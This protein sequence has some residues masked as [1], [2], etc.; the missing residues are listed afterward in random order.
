MA[1]NQ[2][3]KKVW[4]FPLLLAFLVM[5]LAGQV[6]VMASGNLPLIEAGSARV[7]GETVDIPVTLRNISGIESGSFKVTAAQGDKL[8]LEDISL[9][10]REFNCTHKEVPGDMGDMIEIQFLS[11]NG[12]MDIDHRGVEVVYLTY[13]LGENVEAGETLDIKLTDVNLK[14]ASDA[15]LSLDVFSGT[16]ERNYMLGDLTGKDV[17]SPATTTR[18]LQHSMGHNPIEDPL[19][20][21][22]ADLNGDG[23][24]DMRDARILMDYLAGIRDSFFSIKTQ[25]NLPN[26]LVGDTYTV[27]LETAHGKA[28]YNWE[29]VTR[30]DRLPH[31][32]E[33]NQETGVISGTVENSRHA[34]E[35]SFTLQVTD[36]QGSLVEREFTINVTESDIVSVENIPHIMVKVGET[37]SLPHQVRVTYKDDTTGSEEVSWES[38]DTSKV[39][40]RFITGTVGESGLT[41]SAELTVLENSFI[42]D[43]TTG[44]LQLLNI[45][46]LEVEAQSPVFAIKI[47]DMFMHYEGGNHFSLATTTLDPDSRI[48]LEVYDRFGN[49]LENKRI[50]LD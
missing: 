48:T 38:V 22:A 1:L 15:T 13:A 28:P 10:S 42:K 12:S 16:V 23:V 2:A 5:A 7:M 18:I 33:L 41:I 8:K 29:P 40:T 32:L 14:N 19:A 50:K 47:N 24:V 17:I 4:V 31:G 25:G 11:R 45:Y 21:E 46:T 3:I 20:L 49:L 34:G 9:N 39:G 30:R 35:H 27:E 44:Y 6:T 37:P 43:V 26:A 36:R